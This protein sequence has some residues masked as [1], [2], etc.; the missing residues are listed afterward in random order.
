MLKKQFTLYLE[1]RPGELARVTNILAKAKI[2]IEGISAYASAAVGLMQVVV[3]NAQR[4]RSLL[5]RSG[6][7]FTVQDVAVVALP[8]L[9]GALAAITAQL[10]ASGLNITF[11]YGTAYGC[12]G[13]DESHCRCNVVIS[14][15]DPSRLR[16][17]KA[18]IL[19]AA[20]V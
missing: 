12:T 3:S 9:P 10:A 13:D 15:P 18:D 14:A 2:N 6:V 19:A 4:M 17:I 11:L 7:A 16:E 20:A 8:N 5:K 1:D